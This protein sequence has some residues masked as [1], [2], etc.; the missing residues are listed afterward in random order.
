MR[1]VE[2]ITGLRIVI[3]TPTRPA[4]RVVAQGAVA[5]EAA[6]VMSVL[7]A[8]R[9]GA[10]RVLERSGA[11]ALL[12]GRYRVTANQRKSRDVVIESHTPPPARFLVAL[13]AAAAELSFMGIVFLVTRHAIRS[14]L[15]PIEVAGMTG[16]ALDLRML[17]AQWELGHP[18]MIEAH[19]LPFA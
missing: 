18:V 9:T 5:R 15:V 13:F 19:R 3:E 2:R 10:R 17:A 16:V 4:V 7:V 6:F 14:E 8:A 12:A 1:S 11:M